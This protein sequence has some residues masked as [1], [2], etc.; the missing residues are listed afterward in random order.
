[1]LQRRVHPREAAFVQLVVPARLIGVHLAFV[2]PPAEHT[3]LLVEGV[4]LGHEE[5]GVREEPHVL[6]V[7]AV[8]RQRVVNQPAEKRDVGAGANLDEAIGD[9]RRPVEARIDAHQLGVAIS[10]RLHD[11]TETDGMVFSRIA[12][13]RQHDIRIADV[14]PAVG[15]RSSSERGGQTGHRRA[16]S[17]SGLLLDRDDTQTGAEGFDE[18]V[19]ELVGIGAAADD[20]DSGQR[21]DRLPAGILARQAAASRVCFSWRAIRSIA[22]SQDFS[23]QTRLPGAR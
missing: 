4:L 11:E 1:M 8:A 13:H 19:I 10:L 17:Y 7:I 20:A 12:T 5:R 22:Q 15:H 18:E 21:V 6:V 2:V 3:T 16:V 9:R 23:S 14:G